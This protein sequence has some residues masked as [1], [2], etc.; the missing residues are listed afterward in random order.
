[1]STN[2]DMTLAPEY[3]DLCRPSATHHRHRQRRG[4]KEC[5]YDR[6]RGQLALK[7][8]PHLAPLSEL[9]QPRGD[10]SSEVEGAS[11]TYESLSALLPAPQ[12]VCGSGEDRWPHGRPTGPRLVKLIWGL[13]LM[14]V[15]R[16]EILHASGAWSILTGS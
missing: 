10:G 4:Q 12:S 16:D 13:G 14:L 5:D 8:V 1:M 3:Q 15:S 11:R 6:S 9:P 2:A 7:H